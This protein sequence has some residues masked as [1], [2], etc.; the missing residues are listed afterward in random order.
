VLRQPLR[1][2]RASGIELKPLMP[3]RTRRTAVCILVTPAVPAGV[4][5]VQSDP[6]RK[7]KKTV[8]CESRGE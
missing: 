7:L 2:Q 4:W 6:D 5:E 1:G 8:R 3:Y